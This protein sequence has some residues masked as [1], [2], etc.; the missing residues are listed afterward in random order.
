M[1]CRTVIFHASLGTS[2]QSSTSTHSFA[3]LMAHCVTVV[4]TPIQVARCNRRNTRSRRSRNCKRSDAIVSDSNGLTWA[5][6]RMAARPYC[7][8]ARIERRCVSMCATAVGR[9][10]FGPRQ[11]ESKKKLRA[12]TEVGSDA[13]RPK[14]RFNGG[15]LHRFR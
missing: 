13:L 10:R 6:S 4:E 14:D 2:S 8:V 15:R 12:T 7:S 9:S 5:P 1:Q 11:P 3:I